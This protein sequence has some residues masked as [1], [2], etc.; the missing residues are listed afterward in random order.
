LKRRSPRQFLYLT[1]TG[2]VSGKPR[3][4]EIWYMES[5]GRYYLLSEGGRKADW[6]RN[7]ER[8][9]KVRVAIGKREFAATA[10]VLDAARDPEAWALA[11]RLGRDKYGWGDGLPV[12]IVPEGAGVQGDAEVG[13]S[14]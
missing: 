7:I 10:R 6:V 2:R 13:R 1:T 5:D 14:T 12:E 9:P 11:Q 8:D 4:I 3:E